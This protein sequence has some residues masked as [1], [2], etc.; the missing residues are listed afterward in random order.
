MTDPVQALEAV[1][2]GIDRRIAHDAICI[3]ERFPTNEGCDCSRPQRVWAEQARMVERMIREALLTGIAQTAVLD[4]RYP[5]GVPHGWDMPIIDAGWAAALRAVA[6]NALQ[7]GG[8]IDRTPRNGF[9]GHH[10]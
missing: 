5:E 2:R 1:L 8:E 3:G 6:P 9:E 4:L 10:A 7:A